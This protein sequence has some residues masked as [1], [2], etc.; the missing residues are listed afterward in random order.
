MDPTEPALTAHVELGCLRAVRLGPGIACDPDEENATTRE[1]I[2][3]ALDGLPAD[4][5][6]PA[7]AAHI[8]A[9][10]PYGVTLLGWTPH[11]LAQTLREQL[12]GEHNTERVGQFTAQDLDSLTASWKTIPWQVIPAVPLPA[13]VNVALDEVLS[14][15]IAAGVVPPTLRFWD[16]Q[17]P[18]VII[19]R[20]QSVANEIDSESRVTVVRRMTGGG[21]M[22]IE[23]EGAITYSLIVS[24]TAVAGLTIRQSY[25]VCDGWVVRTL[26]SLG[27]DCHH[28]PVNDLGWAGGK[29][30][31]AAQARRKGVVVHH[32]TLAYRLDPGTL[33]KTLRIGRPR[34]SERAVASARKQVSPLRDQTDIPRTAIVQAL[35]EWFLRVFG[36]AECPLDAGL[37]LE[38]ERLVGQKYAQEEWLHAFR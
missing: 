38:A 5:P 26:R 12:P 3:R 23:P 31:G 33:A 1:A 22:I 15:Q 6:A 36:G 16:W 37:L 14:D 35:R 17:E 30:G 34:V 24:E 28:I 19:G 4:L 18:A 7:L 8:R 32:T 20:C 13:A 29:I 21:A 2:I 11:Q 27:I 25:E 10:I 9:A